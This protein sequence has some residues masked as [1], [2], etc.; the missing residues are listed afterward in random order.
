MILLVVED[1]TGVE[2]FAPANFRSLVGKADLAYFEQLIR[3]LPRRAELNPKLL[4]DQLSSL[5][6]GT[7]VTGLVGTCD[8]HSAEFERIRSGLIQI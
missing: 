4:F 3:D 6:V 8:A 1:Q 2:L 7:V 5:S